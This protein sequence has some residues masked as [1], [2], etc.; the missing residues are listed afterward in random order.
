MSRPYSWASEPQPPDG[1]SPEMTSSF[2]MLNR[3][4][5]HRTEDHF[6]PPSPTLP[7]PYYHYRH[8]SRHISPQIPS[9]SEP[10]VPPIP[11]EFQ[12]S[13][14]PSAVHQDPPREESSPRILNLQTLPSF[15]NL[16]NQQSF[17]GFDEISLD[18]DYHHGTSS[19]RTRYPY[20]DPHFDP[21]TASGRTSLNPTASSDAL[22][23]ESRSSFDLTIHG[24]MPA[25]DAGLVPDEGATGRA[26][27]TS[28][29]VGLTPQTQKP[30]GGNPDENFKPKSLRFWLIMLSNFLAIFLVALDRTIIATAIPRITD[31][32]KSLGDIGWY[33]SAYM[34]T[35]AA[36][37]LL[38]GR[39]YKFYDTKW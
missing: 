12:A 29:M 5:N 31:D 15:Q 11:P 35:T 26:R 14:R 37:Q 16:H 34:L 25:H 21:S 39:I 8:L 18:D 3:P 30:P 33:G 9:A 7:R 38:F 22:G 1:A 10:P 24:P 6:T 27:P 20:H 2:T 4:R 23:L 19:R 36:S 32:F 17:H 13:G 28:D